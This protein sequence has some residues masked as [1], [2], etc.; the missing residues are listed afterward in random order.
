MRKLSAL[1]GL[2]LA[3]VVAAIS[4]VKSG[5][6]LKYFYDV[7]GIFIVV[8]GTIA[9]VFMSYSLTDVLRVASICMKIFLREDKT[10][11]A[12][13][14]EL[15]KFAEQCSNSGIPTEAKGVVHPFLNDCLGLINDGYSESEMRD[16]L[17][18]RIMSI[19]ESEKYDMSIVRAVSKYPPTFGMYGTVVG[20]IALMATIGG[21]TVDMKKIGGYMAIALTTTLYGIMIANFMFKP[22]SDNLE[23]GSKINMKVRQLVLE[24]VLLIKARASLLIIQDTIN[25]QI[26]PRDMISYV[27]GA[28]GTKR[29]G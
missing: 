18:Q 5:V 29:V 11:K 7:L 20:L 2:S 3:L 10:Y 21:D 16:M 27:G 13:G 22:I 28:S 25:S 24:T 15:M 9:A 12:I 8:G 4:L 17:E 19:Y 6:D 14:M 23:I 1:I 26:P